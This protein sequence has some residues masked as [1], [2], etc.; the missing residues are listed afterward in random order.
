MRLCAKCRPESRAGGGCRGGQ[1]GAHPFPCY[2]GYRDCSYAEVELFTGRTHQI[3]A[4]A[5]HIGMPLA[6]DDRYASR[7]SLRKWKKRGLKPVFLHAIAWV[8]NAVGETLAFDAPLPGHCE[9]SLDGLEPCM[10]IS[11]DLRPHC[12]LV[13]TGAL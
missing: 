1:I 7:E 13:K 3:R 6:G 11:Y 4:H 8:E 2:E 9:K 12:P 10:L 5:Q